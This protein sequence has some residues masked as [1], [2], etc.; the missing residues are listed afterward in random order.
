MEPD[1][2]FDK[3]V[4]L[5]INC[6]VRRVLVRHWIDLGKMSARTVRCVVT[7]SGALMRLPHIS[8]EVD[9]A[10]PGSILDE[11]REDPGR[12]TP[13]D[14][15]R[16]LEWGV[17]RRP[18]FGARVFELTT[19]PALPRYSRFS[20]ASQ[21]FL[22]HV[23]RP[24]SGSEHNKPTRHDVIAMRPSTL[25]RITMRHNVLAPP[26]INYRELFAVVT[27]APRTPRFCC[28]HTPHQ[29][30]PCRFSG[31]TRLLGLLGSARNAW[32]LLAS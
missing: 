4:D 2:Q 12:T 26:L 18:V 23:Q 31:V 30:I 11:I 9:L 5:D 29:S 10:T 17:H 28:R 8:P 21:T 3:K 13:P 6:R 32:S 15:P 22:S 24:I 19:L 7:L 20:S 1:K 25:E 16:Q 14:K 27:L